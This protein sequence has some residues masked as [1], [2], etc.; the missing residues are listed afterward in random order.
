MAYLQII[1]NLVKKKAYQLLERLFLNS[2]YLFLIFH[3]SGRF[4]FS[5]THIR[6]QKGLYKNGP[7][8]C[9]NH[10]CKSIQIILRFCSIYKTLKYNVGYA[11]AF[12]YTHNC[13]IVTTFLIFSWLGYT[14]CISCSGI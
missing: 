9:L 7:D 13:W 3:E 10:F 1:L 11:R 12:C 8:F 14:S 2:F 6:K 5:I 4:T